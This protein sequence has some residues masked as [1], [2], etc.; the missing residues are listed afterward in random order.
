MHR[1]GRPF[2]LAGLGLD[3]PAVQHVGDFPVGEA[4]FAEVPH[5]PEDFEL[6]LVDD[7]PMIAP[8][9]TK[10][11]LASSFVFAIL[12]TQGDIEVLEILCDGAPGGKNLRRDFLR[13]EPFDDVL[14]VQEVPALIGFAE[15]KRNDFT[16]QVWGKLRLSPAEI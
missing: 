14:L 16:V 1:L 15:G 10:S 11:E 8:S 13:R 4:L 5:F 6:A 9:F 3:A 2:G 7:H 12:G